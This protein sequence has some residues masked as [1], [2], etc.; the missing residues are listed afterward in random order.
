[1]TGVALTDVSDSAKKG[2][3]VEDIGISASKYIVSSKQIPINNVKL[4]VTQKS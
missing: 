3:G 1:M 2:F 4:R